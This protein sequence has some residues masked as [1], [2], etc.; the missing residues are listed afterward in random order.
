MHFYG[1]TGKSVT[2]RDAQPLG[3]AKSIMYESECATYLPPRRTVR[4]RRVG[5]SGKGVRSSGFFRIPLRSGA[6]NKRSDEH[7]N[8]DTGRKFLARGNDAVY[9]TFGTTCRTL[10]FGGSTESQI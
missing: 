1:I 9:G 7:G 3:R 5:Q 6:G 8:D 2:R 10:E 4:A